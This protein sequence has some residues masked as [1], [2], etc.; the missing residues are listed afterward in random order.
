MYNYPPK[1]GP[2]GLW[3]WSSTQYTVPNDLREV[4]WDRNTI[5]PYNNKPGAYN[6]TSN[7][8]WVIASIPKGPPGC[9]IPSS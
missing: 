8:R 2:G 9:P 4:C 6:G 7:A 5:S 3:G 1:L